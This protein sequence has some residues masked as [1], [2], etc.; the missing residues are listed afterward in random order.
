MSEEQKPE[1]TTDEKEE[2]KEVVQ[3][4]PT[5]EELLHNREAELSR[6][7]AEIERMRNELA[8]KNQVKPSYNANDITT[9]PDHELRVLLKDPK[10]TQYHNQA[11]D[12]LFDRKMEVKLAAKAESEKRVSAEMQLR[13]QFPEALDSSSELGAKVEQIMQENDLSRTP[14]GRLVAAKLAA[15]ELGQGKTASDARGQKI[16]KDRVSRVKGQMVDGDRPK[17]TDEG[18]NL[19]EKRQNLAEK[20]IKANQSGGD[21][22]STEAMGEILKDRFGGRDGFF[23]KK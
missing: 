21:K 6:K 8:A 12:I 4:K 16:E 11:E 15:A 23:G 2:G 19:D 5:T 7:N 20:L 9:W 3:E 1:V 10:F 17:P 22:A 18:K 14:A 13:K